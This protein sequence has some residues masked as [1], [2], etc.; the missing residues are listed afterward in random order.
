MYVLTDSAN[1][2]ALLYPYTVGQLKAD[3]PGVI[4]PALNA[5]ILEPLN[6]RSVQPTSPPVYDISTQRLVELYPERLTS[7]GN[8]GQGEGQGQ[9]AT[10]G[11]RQRW[12]VVPL[13]PEEIQTQYGSA[14]AAVAEEAMRRFAATNEYLLVALAE[15]VPLSIEMQAYRAALLAYESLPG[16]PYAVAWP[17]QPETIYGA[18]QGLPIDAY[19]KSEVDALLSGG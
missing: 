9:T 1:T 17:S 10:T 12:Q 19:T 8:Q 13:T 3:N 7:G 5:D 14:S 18:G 6:A 4:F 16:F 15:A 2:T 11:W